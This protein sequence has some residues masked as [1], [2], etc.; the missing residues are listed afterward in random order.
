MVQKQSRDDTARYLASED[1]SKKR[2]GLNRKRELL[3]PVRQVSLL[4]EG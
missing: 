3:V 1:L 2:K 4:T